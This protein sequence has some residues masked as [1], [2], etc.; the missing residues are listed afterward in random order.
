MEIVAYL[1]YMIVAFSC[2][3]I[4]VLGFGMF[5]QTVLPWVIFMVALFAPIL[6]IS[7]K[8]K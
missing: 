2:Y 6:W 7:L 3:M 8:N 1:I 4:Y 5:V